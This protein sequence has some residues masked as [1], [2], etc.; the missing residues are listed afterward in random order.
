MAIWNLNTVFY[1]IWTI[2]KLFHLINFQTCYI[3]CKIDS[4]ICSWLWAKIYFASTVIWE[5][6]SWI[7]V[8]CSLDS[9]FFLLFTS[10][11]LLLSIRKKDR[12]NIESTRRIETCDIFWQAFYSSISE[13]QWHL[14][15]LGIKVIFTI[16]IPAKNFEK[17]SLV[18]RM[19]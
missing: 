6:F 9:E 19:F 17:Y 16:S 4:K 12:K 8:Y 10:V 15:R 3:P 13:K 2:K 11:Y 5:L 14:K 1:W 18:L 7:M